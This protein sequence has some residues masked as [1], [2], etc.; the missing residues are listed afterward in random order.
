MHGI[1]KGP[2]VIAGGGI[3]SEKCL[4]GVGIIL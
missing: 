3:W 4:E 1:Q 2:E